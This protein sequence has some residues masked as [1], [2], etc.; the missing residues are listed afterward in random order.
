M[1]KEKVFGKKLKIILIKNDTAASAMMHM[2]QFFISFC[3]L[4]KE[5]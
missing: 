4:E 3:F 5:L 1:S 2:Q